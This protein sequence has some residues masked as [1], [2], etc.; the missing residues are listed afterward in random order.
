MTSD[1]CDVSAAM[2]SLRSPRC[3]DGRA[4]GQRLSETG[5]GQRLHKLVGVLNRRVRIGLRMRRRRV[6]GRRDGGEGVGVTAHLRA[7]Y[8]SGQGVASNEAVLA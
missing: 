4:P 2:T 7:A 3:A 5:G 8:E 1:I 6:V